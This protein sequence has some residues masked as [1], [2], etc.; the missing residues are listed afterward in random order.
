LSM[1]RNIIF[2]SSILL[3]YTTD[4]GRGDKVVS[5]T[6]TLHDE[7]GERAGPAIENTSEI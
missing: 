7:R 3:L 5:N 1:K 4:K 6:V 2:R